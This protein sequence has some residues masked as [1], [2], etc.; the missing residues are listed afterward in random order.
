M[1]TILMTLR[2]D[3]CE[4]SGDSEEALRQLRLLGARFVEYGTWQCEDAEVAF[5]NIR[6]DDGGNSIRLALKKDEHNVSIVNSHAHRAA[7]LADQ[8]DDEY[9]AEY[10]HWI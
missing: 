1:A 3:E 5:V 4:H 10:E 2:I 9:H 7:E 6:V 8:E